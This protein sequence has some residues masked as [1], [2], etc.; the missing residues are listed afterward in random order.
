VSSDDVLD[1]LSLVVQRLFGIG[2]EVQCAAGLAR[3][4]M[5][6]RLQLVVDKLDDLICDARSVAFGRRLRADTAA[7]P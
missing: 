1:A 5:A 7:R 3:G 6:D 2:L 4:P